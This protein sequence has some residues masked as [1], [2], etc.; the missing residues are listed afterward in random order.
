MLLYHHTSTTRNIRI[1][2]NNNKAFCGTFP[3]T[4]CIFSTLV[5]ERFQVHKVTS[6]VLSRSSLGNDIVFDRSFP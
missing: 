3:G 2:K 4:P 1:Y 5:L 6:K